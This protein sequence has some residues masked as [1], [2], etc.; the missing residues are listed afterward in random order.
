[1]SFSQILTNTAYSRVPLGNTKHH[2]VRL[3]FS[4]QI[5]LLSSTRIL[6]V[7]E[8]L[9]RYHKQ[10]RLRSYSEFSSKQILKARCVVSEKKFSPCVNI[11]SHITRGYTCGK[12]TTI[13]SSKEVF[14]NYTRNI[15]N[16][17]RLNKNGFEGSL[18]NNAR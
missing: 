1:M 5:L 11:S 16:T 15:S 7:I 13:Q 2:F 12:K 17:F 10:L 6:I 14:C 3:L 9:L 8:N 18:L 4:T